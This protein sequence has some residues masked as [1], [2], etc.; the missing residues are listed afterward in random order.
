MLN[1]GNLL[2]WSFFKLYLFWQYFVY[3]SIIIYDLLGWV[4]E[5]GYTAGPWGRH[6][7]ARGC[8]KATQRT[9]KGAPTAS[10]S[11]HSGRTS[12]ADILKKTWRSVS[13][14]KLVNITFKKKQKKKNILLELNIWLDLLWNFMFIGILLYGHTKFVQ[15]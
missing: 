14:I 4:W 5:G 7:G 2:F 13:Q 11:R 9:S 8:C 12:L 3:S 6:G 10:P 1:S 15:Y